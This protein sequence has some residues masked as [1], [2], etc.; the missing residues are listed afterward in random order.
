MPVGT[1]AGAATARLDQVGA[2]RLLEPHDQPGTDRL[3]DRWGAALLPR[4]RVVQVAVADRVDEGH[5]AAP[6]RGGDAVADQLAADHQHPRGLRAADE[7]V[8]GEEDRV[9]VRSE[10]HT[11]E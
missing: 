5:R 9:L 1:G 11:S 8:R 10:E 4:D 7:L 2:D 3:D 6:W